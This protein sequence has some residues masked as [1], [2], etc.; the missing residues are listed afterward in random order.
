ME[1]IQVTKKNN[2]K[3]DIICKSNYAYDILKGIIISIIN[4]Y[5]T[6]NP[7]LNERYGDLVKKYVDFLRD[8]DK[9]FIEFCDTLKLTK[10]LD[11]DL[12]IDYTK[13][14]VLK[15]EKLLTDLVLADTEG[16]KQLFNLFID[17]MSNKHIIAILNKD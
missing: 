7:D 14:D 8:N 1:K 12:N 4:A 3:L 13:R 16:I 6:N 15:C 5:F 10:D 17:E 2:S 9:T 11:K